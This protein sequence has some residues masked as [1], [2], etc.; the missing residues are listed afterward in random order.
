MKKIYITFLVLITVFISCN[1]EEDFI[2]SSIKKEENFFRANAKSVKS[3]GSF[4]ANYIDPL[5]S[6][7]HWASFLVIQTLLKHQETR[8]GFLTVYNGLLQNNKVI[9]LE[10]LLDFNNPDLTLF[11]QKFEIE[12]LYYRENPPC[13]ERPEGDVQPETEGPTGNPHQAV[14]FF[15]L[16]V[17]Y[18]LE[19]DCIEIYMPNGINFEAEQGSILTMISSAHPLTNASSNE[20]I[21]SN[22]HCSDTEFIMLDENTL[23]N[24]IIARP[25][26][27]Q[28]IYKK[29]T[30]SNYSSIEDFTDFLSN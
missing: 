1:Q 24:V 19:D 11:I 25:Y 22:G 20:A 7:L 5:E 12:F 30:Y 15:D 18:L 9:K 4:A 13:I 29:C 26:R 2:E 17:N 10:Q 28:G 8:A 16:Y 3:G 27:P 6:K 23:G 21:Q 14:N